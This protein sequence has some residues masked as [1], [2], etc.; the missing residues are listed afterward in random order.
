M[1]SVQELALFPF[2][3]FTFF[4][5]E[6]PK[7]VLGYIID[8]W[9]YILQLPII[10]AFKPVS[11]SAYARSYSSLFSI[12]HEAA[13][14]EAVEEAKGTHRCHWRRV[15]RCLIGRACHCTRFRCCSI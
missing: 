5:Y 7:R 2:T 14:T 11:R 12:T 1:H 15:D 13:P 8:T 6:L 9:Y 4:F 10:W 3:L